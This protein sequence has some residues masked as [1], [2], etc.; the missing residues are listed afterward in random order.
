MLIKKQ[1]RMKTKIEIL[2]LS[3]RTVKSFGSI[4][5]SAGK[6][7]LTWDL[8]NMQAGSKRQTVKLVVK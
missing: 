7:E 6:H 8:C 5:R 1:E 2:D 3:G 4:E